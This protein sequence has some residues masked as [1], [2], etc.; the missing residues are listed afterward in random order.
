MLFRDLCDSRLQEGK[1]KGAVEEDES[2]QT[3]I[4]TKWN[5]EDRLS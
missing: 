2:D 4:G 1:W 3:E 5:E